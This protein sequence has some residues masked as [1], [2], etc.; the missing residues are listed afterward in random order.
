[1]EVCKVFNY[2]IHV[3]GLKSPKIACGP[4]NG[5]E[6]DTTFR[7]TERVVEE[8]DPWGNHV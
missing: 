6:E 3:I 2:K 1:M 5:R 7:E 4:Y 8:V